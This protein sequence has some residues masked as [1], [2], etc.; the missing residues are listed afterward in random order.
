MYWVNDNLLEDWIQLPDATP[1]HIKAARQIK[2]VLTGNLNATI[3]S[4]PPF[5]G[6]ERHFLRAQIARITHG[7]SLIPKGLMEVDEEGKE[8]FAEEFNVPGT[9]E[10]KT[11]EAWS[12][13]HPQILQAGRIKHALSPD[14]NPETAEEEMA[15]LNEKDPVLEGNYRAV[16]EDGAVTGLPAGL[17]TGFA[18]TTKVVGDTQPYNQMP[19][20]EG[21]TTYSVNVIKSL[22]WPGAVTVAQNGRFAS[23]YVG[24][25]LKKGDNCFN[26]IEPPEIQRDPVD[27]S[28]MPEPTPL[29]APEQLPE[30]DTEADKKKGEEGAEE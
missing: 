24:Y 4:N 3:D 9:E 16:N 10:L 29:I 5:P 14:T 13:Q 28:E 22:R 7:T 11:L 15:K 8:K 30:P 17:E 6:K 23:I 26:P 12:H 18:W 25:G 2:H 1:A 21:T 19:G 20:K 27:Q